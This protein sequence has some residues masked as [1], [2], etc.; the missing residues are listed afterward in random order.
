[1]FLTRLI[2]VSTITEK[3]GPSSLQDILNVG[4]LNNTKNGITGMLCFNNKYFIQCLEGSRK[5]V[6][7]AYRRIVN[8][9]RHSNIVILEYN[10][11]NYREFSDWCMGCIPTS[12]FT[13][14]L[15]LKFSKSIE[16]R[17]YE[18][19]GTSV[20]MLLLEFKKDHTSF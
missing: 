14:P 5:D 16:F 17:P 3:F 12:K 1:M 13:D 19:S 20:Y 10:Q 9:D 6:N 15:I 18:M 11:I 8:D 2:Y 4:R 7:D